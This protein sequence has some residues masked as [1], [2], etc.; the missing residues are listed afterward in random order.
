MIHSDFIREDFEKIIGPTSMI[1]TEYTKII[2][3]I[4]SLNDEE[5]KIYFNDYTD[6]EIID[7][8]AASIQYDFDFFMS[9]IQ[10]Y[11]DLFGLKI[12]VDKSRSNQIESDEASSV[13]NELNSIESKINI[14]SRIDISEKLIQEALREGD[15]SI[16]YAAITNPILSEESILDFIKNSSDENKKEICKKILDA[17]KIS[18][19]EASPLPLRK[20]LNNK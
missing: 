15:N 1:L 19:V 4:S 12:I 13:Y 8:V 9:S 7:F 3:Y 17:K 5:F 14:I 16:F 10:I 6:S 2:N 11:Q 18:Y 20:H